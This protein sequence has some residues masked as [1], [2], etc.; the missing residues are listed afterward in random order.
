MYQR[1]KE[2]TTKPMK[3]NINIVNQ[4]VKDSIPNT[5][6]VDVSNIGNLVNYSV[7]S[8]ICNIL[9]YI[10]DTEFE[11]MVSDLLGKIRE[12]GNVIIKFVNFKK[13][14]ITYI[15]QQSSGSEVFD[16]LKNKKN[17]LSP[18]KI[19]NVLNRH[20]FMI[21]KIDQQDNEFI[22]MAQRAENR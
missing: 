14:F 5:N 13:I 7:D 9:E 4:F 20:H 6:Q 8:I 1:D 21:L 2:S 18:D 12:G 15:N 10:D 17:I 22:I 16:F 11:A 19:I 3:R